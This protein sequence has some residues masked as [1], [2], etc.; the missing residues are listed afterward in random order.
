MIE[1]HKDSH[2]H[3]LQGQTPD[4]FA[5]AIPPGGK[6]LAFSAR[7]AHQMIRCLSPKLRNQ[8]FQNSGQHFAMFAGILGFWV[9]KRQLLIGKSKMSD[10]L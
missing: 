10:R 6:G 5:A 9:G 4:Q 3:R 7:A 1:R 8:D 2:R